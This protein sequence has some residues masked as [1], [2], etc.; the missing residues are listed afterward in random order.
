[1]AKKTKTHMQLNK[2]NNLQKMTWP[3]FNLRSLSRKVRLLPSQHPTP[4]STEVALGHTA[5]DVRLATGP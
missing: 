2:L 4:T 1:M 3:G 5:L